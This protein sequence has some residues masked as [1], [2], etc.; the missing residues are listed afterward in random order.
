M[1]VGSNGTHAHGPFNGPVDGLCKGSHLLMDIDRSSDEII[2]AKAIG[3]KEIINQ[4]GYKTGQMVHDDTTECPISPNVL[5]GMCFDGNGN[6][7]KAYV[8]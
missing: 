2:G 7:E 4:S 1:E 3:I 6:I 8:C 5:K